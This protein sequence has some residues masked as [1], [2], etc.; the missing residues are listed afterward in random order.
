ML[1][2]LDMPTTRQGGRFTPSGPSDARAGVV[3]AQVER[4]MAAARP[5]LVRMA[6]SL[7]VAADSAD[8]VAQ[9]TL[10]EAW[11]HLDHLASPTAFD[12]WLSGICHNVCRRHA[13][14]DGLLSRRQV[15]LSDPS[16]SAA[17]EWDGPEQPG[18]AA[19]GD[20][21][22][23]DPFTELERQDLETLLDRALGYLPP[24]DREATLLCYL[25]ELPQREVALRLGLT[26]RALESR[27]LRARKRLRQVLAEELRAEAETFGLAP[28]DGASQGWRETRLWC[29]SCGRRRMQGIFETLP[30][31][32][33]A[34]AMRCP[35]CLRHFS[36]R[37]VV[38]LAG[39]RS[40]RPAYKRLVRHLSTYLARGVTSGWQAC[41]FCGARQPVRIVGPEQLGDRR[42]RWPGLLVRIQCAACGEHVDS[43]ASSLLWS[44]GEP[45]RFM[46][47]YPR[48]IQQPET[49]DDYL[50]A[51]AIRLHLSAVSSTAQLTMLAHA[52]TL[53]VLATF[54][55]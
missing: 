37:G 22:A 14:A 52:R 42:G 53:Q 2:P 49:L 33:V 34:L 7:G 47:R 17:E 11:R 18:L 32:Q 10:L 3:A 4:W 1:R 55:S 24:R 12:A 29:W 26:I 39:I 20:P 36:S 31:N 40:F 50:G 30:G 21:A 54:P 27:L 8:D 13:R 15:R 51:P 28:D 46:A 35:G 45:Q 9:E 25:S 48:W 6:C 43:T 41:M 38:P 5:R 19:T 44:H 23:G 16:A